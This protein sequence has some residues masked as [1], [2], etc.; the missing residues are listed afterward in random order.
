MGVGK[1]GVEREHRNLDCKSQEKRQEHK[2]LRTQY[3]VKN[4]TGSLD[5]EK[6]HRREAELV[7]VSVVHVDDC[8][9]HK[10]ASK[11]RIN[12]KFYCRIDPSRRS[13]DS[14]DEIHGNQYRL[15]EYE[16]KNHIQCCEGP[17][18]R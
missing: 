6:V 18:E 17:D 14:Y 9:Q 12:E 5:I 8:N 3:A 13:P 7:Y 16:E 1:P 15:P 10:P 4:K 11:R 2:S